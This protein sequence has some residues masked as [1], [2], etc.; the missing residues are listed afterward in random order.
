M[1]TLYFTLRSTKQ[2]VKKT[3]KIY[4]A[5]YHKRKV[6]Y[7]ATDYEVD[8]M[9]QFEKGVVVCRKD[10]KIMNQR[11]A[12]TLSVYQERLNELS[13]LEAYTCAQIKDALQEKKREFQYVTLVEQMELRIKNLRKEGRD[14]YADMNVQTLAN[15]KAILGDISLKSISTLTIDKFVRGLSGLSNATKQI[16]LTHF[17]AC[18]NEAIRD[19]MVKYKVHP[20]AYTKMP[21]SPARMLDLTL[22][23]FASIRDYHTRYRKLSLA[24]DLFLLSFYLGGM[25]L[26]DLVEADFSKNQVK[27]IRKKT[28]NKKQGEKT[29][30]FSIP[31]EAKEIIRKYIKR[32]GKLDFGYKFSYHNFQRYLNH[33]LKELK[34]VLSIES[35]ICYYSARKTFCQFAFDLGI[36]TEIIEYCIGQSM[37][38]NRPIYN[39]VRVM[40]RQADAAI[41]RV[42]DY[43]INPDDFELNITNC[44]G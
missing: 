32:N 29:V 38:D 25:N 1:A 34:K 12:Y 39:Y 13:D 35:N 27:Y 9:Y 33:N 23:E 15:I 42:I 19:G 4:L 21:K 36:R 3:Y 44:A 26:A 8:D 37:K 41:R 40:Q 14:S 5:I 7:L 30:I 28:S 20:F 2:T 24:R 31:P 11:L 17:K 22:E 6:C 10:A 16:R 18:L 43:T